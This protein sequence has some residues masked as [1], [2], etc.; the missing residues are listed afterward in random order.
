MLSRLRRALTATPAARPLRRVQDVVTL[1]LDGRTVP[2]RRLRDA[3]C[4]RM[5]LVVDERGARLSMPLRASQAAAEAFVRGHGQWLP[6]QLDTLGQGLPDDGPALAIGQT[7]QL[8]LLGQER[9]VVWVPHRHTHLVL[10]DGRLLF[11]YS[12]R[13]GQAALARALG[14]F[15]L[16][17]ARAQIGP[18]VARWLGGLPRAPRRFVFKQMSSMWGSLAPDGT[19]RLDLSLVLAPP[20]ALQYVLVHELCHL[21]QP[22]HSPAFWAEVQKRLPDWQAQRDWLGVEGRRIKYRL[23][24][25]VA[26]G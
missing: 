17:Q 25:L 4:R 1:E 9:E 12:A 6:A 20:A 3:R 14:D 2:V 21:I 24:Q 5:R 7:T 16:A 10:E 8:P 23:R 26:V 15:Y 13:A 11:H 18:E 19:V 22:N